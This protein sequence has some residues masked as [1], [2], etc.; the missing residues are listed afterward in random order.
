MGVFS[1]GLTNSNYLCA[2]RSEGSEVSG[3]H[4]CDLFAYKNNQTQRAVR[5]VA[6]MR[7]KQ[8]SITLCQYLE[9]FS[10]FLWCILLAGSLA[11]SQWTRDILSVK[12][13]RCGLHRLC[14]C[15]CV[16]SAYNKCHV[17]TD[18]QTRNHK[19]ITIR[20]FNHLGKIYLMH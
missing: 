11:G 15:V 13:V 8:E 9:G 20:P 1:V 10:F 19:T 5:S 14:I 6:V 2:H 17:C 18:T 16:C 7:F 4:V 3:V 12:S